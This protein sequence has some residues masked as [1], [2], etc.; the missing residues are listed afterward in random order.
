VATLPRWANG[1]GGAPLWRGRQRRGPGRDGLPGPGTGGFAGYAK[2]AWGLTASD[3]PWWYKAHEPREGL[4]DGTITPTGALASLPYTPEASRAALHRFYDDLGGTL[5][6]IYGFRDAYNET[7]D[8][9]APIYMG[10]NQAPIVVM[11]ENY[12]SGL[13]WKLFMANDEIRSALNRLSDL[14]GRLRCQE[15]AI[16][17]HPEAYQ[18]S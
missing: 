7:E 6:G 5:W 4:D 15:T 18:V 12:R 16:G 10:L 14:E 11:I 9:V 1:P 17:L 13:L 3:G 8:W 2:G